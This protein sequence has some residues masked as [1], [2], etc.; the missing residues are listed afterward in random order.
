MRLAASVSLGSPRTS[1]A[2]ATKANSGSKVWK[3]NNL[4]DAR[5]RSKAAIN[6]RYPPNTDRRTA[7]P[8]TYLAHL[9]HRHEHAGFIAGEAL[10]AEFL[11]PVLTQS[12][13]VWVSLGHYIQQN[14][15]TSGLVGNDVG[16]LEDMVHEQA[17]DAQAL[18]F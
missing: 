8:L 7:L 15:V 5:M 12:E 4:S 9:L 10:E 18:R 3:L 13:G 6:L 11:I 1:S 16:F 2:K 14:G 17:A